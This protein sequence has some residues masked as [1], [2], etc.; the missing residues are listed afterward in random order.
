MASKVIRLLPQMIVTL[1]NKKS[2][3]DECDTANITHY[4]VI[5]N[6]PKCYMIDKHRGHC[7]KFQ[8]KSRHLKRILFRKEA[9]LFRDQLPVCLNLI[10]LS[11]LQCRLVSAHATASHQDNASTDYKDCTDDVEDCGTNATSARKSSACKVDNSLR[12]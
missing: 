1:C 4:I 2:V 9:G 5:V 12:S 3:D 8:Y 6:K 7:N 10:Q 11:S